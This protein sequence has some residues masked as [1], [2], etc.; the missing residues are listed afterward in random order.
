MPHEPDA[1]G[2]LALMLFHHAR[3]GARTGADGQLITLEDQ[4]RSLWDG[5]L[6]AQAAAVLRSALRQHRPS[7]YQL[8]AAIAACHAEAPT[9]ADTDWQ[10]ISA[11]YDRLLELAPS[12]VVRLNRAVAVAMAYGLDAGLQLVEEL[13]SEDS[14]A[15]YHRLEATR[16]D[17][18]RRRGDSQAAALAYRRALMLAPS[19]PEKALSDAPPSGAA[20]LRA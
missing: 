13:A 17:L 10:Q 18:L 7:S 6:N 4:D 3:R 14:L 20:A 9:V 8:Q 2:L 16:A 19:E 12:P 11:L 1:T 15:G 5:A